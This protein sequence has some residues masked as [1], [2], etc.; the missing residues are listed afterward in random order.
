[1]TYTERRAQLMAQA[2]EAIDSGNLEQFAQLKAQIE[3][4]DR[5]EEDRRTAQ[6]NLDAMNGLR[7]GG[8]QSA[9]I[10]GGQGVQLN[11]THEEPHDDMLNSLEYR[12]AFMNKVTKRIPMPAKFTNTDYTTTSTTAGTLVP[13]VLVEQIITKLEDAGDIYA[14]VFRTNIPA[15]IAI[16]TTDVKPVAVWVDEDQGSPRQKAVTDKLVFAGY[17]LECKVAFSL[18]MTVTSLEQFESKFVELISEAMLISKESKIISGSGTGCPKGILAETPPT[19]QALQVAAGSNG[20]LT[21]QLLMDAEAALPAA[22]KKAVWLMTKKTFFAWMGITD[23]NG[24]PIAR[25]NAGL[26]DKQ[27]YTLNGRHVCLTDG[28]MGNFAATVSADTIFAALFDL[29]FYEFNE[30]TGVMMMKYVDND[31]DNTVLKAVE[32]GDGKVID[33]NSLVTITKKSA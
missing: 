32:L 25:I 5:K 15:G 22:Y 27:E 20:K 6:A 17:K 9:Q 31:N 28:Y 33:K 10:I 24:Q 23:Q 7:Q 4:L 8:L 3:D 12:R 30:V 19:G 26:S 11:S 14:R 16:P 1:M 21:Y 2:Q 18:F 13:T 29:G